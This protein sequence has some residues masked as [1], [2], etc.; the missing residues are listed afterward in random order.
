MLSQ[1]E[2]IE[3]KKPVFPLLLYA[4]PGKP[5]RQRLSQ[6]L[7]RI[8]AG[9]S[10][11]NGSSLCMGAQ[12]GS[13]SDLDAMARAAVATGDRQRGSVMGAQQLQPVHSRL[14]HIALAGLTT[15]HLGEREVGPAACRPV[16]GGIAQLTSAWASTCSC[17]PCGQQPRLSYRRLYM[18]S[19]LI[20]PWAFDHPR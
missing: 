17:R 13:L 20:Q 8:D 11:V 4:Y 18:R 9:T 19:G 6:Y 7:K 5:Y 10:N 14:V 2:V 3:V 1:P 12:A 15:R 16:V